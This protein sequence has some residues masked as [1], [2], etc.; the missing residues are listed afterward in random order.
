MKHGGAWMKR[1]AF[2][3]SA[4][5]AVAAAASAGYLLLLQSSAG[6]D[7][8]VGR[9][10]SN[11]GMKIEKREF[12]AEMVVDGRRLVYDDIGCMMVH[13]LSFT[14]IIEPVQNTWPGAK[15]E[16][17]MVYVF[18]GGEPV[19]VSTAWFVKGSDVTTPM[20]YDYV[21][22]KSFTDALE[23]S[24]KHGGEVFGWDKAVESFLK[25]RPGQHTDHQHKKYSDAFQIRLR[26]LSGRQTTVSQLLSE[27]KPVLLVFFA[28]WC[29]T[30]SKNTKTLASAYNNF[31]DKVTVLL[32]SFDPGDTESEIRQFLSLHEAPQDWLIAE[33]NLEF[34]VALKV[35]TQ[36]TIFV[37]NTNGEIVYE[38]RFGT[39]T[40]ED[41]MEAVDK[42]D[43]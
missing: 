31:R 32:T 25:P 16:K 3:L 1:R 33:P 43:L 2:I 38:K 17:I 30:C 40:E 23:F 22:F 42:L 41:W 18:D 8:V 21:A 36:E 37:I 6:T 26:L 14:G 39:L 4:G 12:A 28:T 35:V 9:T 29:P 20:R 5:L 27:G 15:I 11:C 24:R 7:S 19:D 10:C 34:M 13:Y